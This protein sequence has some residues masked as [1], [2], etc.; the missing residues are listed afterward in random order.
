MST[1]AVLRRR[2][3]AKPRFCCDSS[4]TPG[5]VPTW[6]LIVKEGGF[7]IPSV[8]GAHSTVQAKRAQR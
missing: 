1:G 6:D 3:S 4:R 8:A 5:P 2:K 7:S